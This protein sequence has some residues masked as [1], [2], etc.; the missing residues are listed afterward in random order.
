[1]KR[2]KGRGQ[3]ID[4]RLS[5]DIGGN[6]KA[7]T[8]AVPKDCAVFGT[9]TLGA[10]DTGALVQMAGTRN[11]LKVNAGK[12]VLLNQRAL[13][14]ALKSAENEKPMLEMVSVEEW[15]R[16]QPPRVEG[17]EPPQGRAGSVTQGGGLGGLQPAPLAPRRV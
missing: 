15:E 2:R 16:T 11:F 7:Y 4:T 12:A 6:W 13:T 8:D 9:V 3:F 17:E 1:M 10:S 5:V 14:A